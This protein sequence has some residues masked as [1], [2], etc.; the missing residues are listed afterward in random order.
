ME[1]GMYWA[2]VTHTNSGIPAEVG[3]KLMTT[4]RSD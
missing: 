2:G 1:E 4:T 3:N